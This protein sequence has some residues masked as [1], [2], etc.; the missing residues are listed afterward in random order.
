MDQGSPEQFLF[1]NYDTKTKG[2]GPESPLRSVK[3]AYVAREYYRKIRQ[4]QMKAWTRKSVTEPWTGKFAAGTEPGKR[5]QSSRRV[6]TVRRPKRT[7]PNL[8]S[9]YELV[10]D[11]SDPRT[12]LGQGR[13]DPFGVFPAERVP[14]LVHELLDHGKQFRACQESGL[15]FPCQAVHECHEEAVLERGFVFL[16]FSGLSLGCSML[17]LTVL[18]A[19]I[20]YWTGLA[21]D[22]SGNTLG[23]VHKAWMVSTRASPLLFYAFVYATSYHYDFVH[24]NQGTSSPT[25]LLRLSYKTQV[26]K[27]VNEMLSDFSRGISDE[28][29]ASILVL[30]FQGPRVK[31]SESSR[32]QSPMAAAQWINHHGSQIFEPEHAIALIQLVRLKGGLKEIRMQGIAE[33]VAV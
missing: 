15:G 9:E 6:F 16:T 23:P 4:H 33:T 17:T 10:E 7:E 1:V 14:L 22:K 26:I 2:Q 20:H 24:D 30:A 27:L 28:L 19:M 12:K 18:K 11:V 32:F 21:P 25:A 31:S 8:E 5:Q 13:L 29:I 3:R